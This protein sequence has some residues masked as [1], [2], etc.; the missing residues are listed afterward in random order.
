M[1]SLSC[2]DVGTGLDRVARSADEEA[3]RQAGTRSPVPQRATP[4]R[5]INAWSARRER[6]N[7]RQRPFGQGAP[8]LE[9]DLVDHRRDRARA[10][11]Q[12]CRRDAMAAARI[13]EIVPDP[14][15]AYAP[16]RGSPCVAA[17]RASSRTRR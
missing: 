7:A 4:A 12:Q 8:R 17:S 3:R 10:F 6:D 15:E 13:V 14:G 11:A 16:L 1:R 5:R 2:V 9:G